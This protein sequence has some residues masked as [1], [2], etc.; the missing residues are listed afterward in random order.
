MNILDAFLFGLIEGVTEFLPVSST[1]HMIL[2]GHI[3]GLGESQFLKSFEI[4]IQLG[5]ILAIVF[6]YRQTIQKDSKTM[7]KVC[8]AFIPTA[9]VG[10]LL[11][12]IIKKYL[13]S[14]DV[15]V[16]SA[17]FIGGLC[18]VLFERMHSKKIQVSNVSGQFDDITYVKALYIGLFQAIAVIPGVSRSAATIIGGELLHVPRKTIVEFSFLLAIPTML[19]ATVLDIYKD[20]T[21][22]AQGNFELLLVGFSTA[23]IIALIVAKFFLRFVERNTF[24]IFGYYRIVLAIVYTLFIL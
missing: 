18:I 24:E 11:Y 15:V 4:V 20:P 9:L 16:V 1:G 2:F 19:A 21:V 6:L 23:F 7:G 8:A 17:L 12:A 3:L 5:A 10:Y 22:F 13:L 14:N